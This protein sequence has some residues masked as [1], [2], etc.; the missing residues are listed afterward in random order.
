MTRIKEILNERHISLKEFAAMLNISYTAL[1]LQINKPSYPTLEKWANVLNVPIWQLFASPEEVCAHQ[2]DTSSDF[3]AYIR[4]D[5]VHLTAD[6]L[7]EFW[8]LVD[9][10]K[11]THPRR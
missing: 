6:T 10:L 11:S 9:E 5:G 3:A 2:Q 7:E 4:C 1:Y 8:H